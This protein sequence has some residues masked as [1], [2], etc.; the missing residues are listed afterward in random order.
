MR[1]R[2]KKYFDTNNKRLY[3]N[4]IIK[5]PDGTYDRIIESDGDLYI[6]GKNN[7]LLDLE[8]YCNEISPYKFILKEGI[9]FKKLTQD[10]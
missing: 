6:L 1:Q 3:G 4:Y 5:Y 10:D 9:R 2:I 7:L 8:G